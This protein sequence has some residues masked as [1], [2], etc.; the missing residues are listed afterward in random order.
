MMRARS[1]NALVGE[2]EGIPEGL[3]VLRTG[4]MSEVMTDQLSTTPHAGLGMRVAATLGGGL[5]CAL[6]DDADDEGADEQDGT[7]HGEP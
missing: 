5:P 7:D 4:E 3:C 2:P 6:T 1:V